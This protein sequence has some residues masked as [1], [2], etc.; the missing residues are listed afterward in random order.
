MHAVI[1]AGGRVDDTFAAAIGSPWKA[2]APL[3]KRRLID[4]AISAARAAGVTAVAVVAPGEVAA[5]CRTSV[6][7]IIPAADDGVENIRRALRAFPEAE[8]L[9]YLTSDLPFVDGPG[10]TTFLTRSREADLTMALADADAYERAFPGA[11]PHLVALG[12]E[13]LANGSVF[14]IAARAIPALER[15][16]GRFFTARKS[17]LRLALLLGPALIA[18]FVLRRLRVSDIE[19]RARAILRVPVLAVRDASPGLCFDIDDIGDWHDAQMRI[20]ALG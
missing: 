15:V 19:A 4:T 8:R 16:A 10:L 20:A 13:R 9:L 6:D 5:Y 12:T 1:T 17:L 18:R 7:L 11:P 3:G 2:L 14:V